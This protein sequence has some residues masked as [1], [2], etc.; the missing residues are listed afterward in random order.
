[1]E[2]LRR[3]GCTDT[4][5]GRAEPSEAVRTL[6]RFECARAREYYERAA[7]ALPPAC[8]GALVA[9]EIMG[10]IYFEILRRIEERGYDVF[11]SRVRVPKP[12]RAIIA[13]GVWTRSGLGFTGMRLG[14]APRP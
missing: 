4:D 8:A 5:L 14:P 3:F 6:L 10:G 13:L 11:S 9:A 2:D 12:V 7:A 1:M